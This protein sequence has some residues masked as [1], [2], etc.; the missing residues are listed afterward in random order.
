MFRAAKLRNHSHTGR[1]AVCLAIFGTL[2]TSP[3]F[4]IDSTEK[5][6]HASLTESHEIKPTNSADV[7][8]KPALIDVADVLGQAQAS[9]NKGDYEKA[10]TTLQDA[11]AF[12]A[13]KK[14][15]REQLLAA[16]Q[17][18]ELPLR[19][20]QTLAELR[21]LQSHGRDSDVGAKLHTILATAADGRIRQKASE[22]LDDHWGFLA[23]YGSWLR[24]IALY[25]VPILG[26]LILRG[27]LA[28]SLCRRRSRLVLA[29]F[30]DSSGRDL[31]SYVS[32][33][34]EYWRNLSRRAQTSG[35]YVMEASSAPVSPSLRL[36]DDNQNLA[37]LLDSIDLKIAGASLEDHVRSYV[38]TTPRLSQKNK[39]IPCV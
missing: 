24:K 21:E 22:Q 29:E 37:K 39:Q 28:V 26:I 27:V 6:I 38:N 11:L 23:F 25:L 8:A 32:S 15:E 20:L 30:S 4:A 12:T 17:R 1:P 18:V 16:L 19:Q 35:L 10:E 34:F 36:D 33:D 5:E 14:D 13:L 7:L 2:L 9:V 3:L 31:Q